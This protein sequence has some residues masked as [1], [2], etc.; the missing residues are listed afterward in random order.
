LIPST[1]ELPNIQLALMEVPGVPSNRSMSPVPETDEL[2]ELHVYGQISGIHPKPFKLMGVVE[3]QGNPRTL[4]EKYLKKDELQAELLVLKKRNIRPV[5]IPSKT[6]LA[7]DFLFAAG[8]IA[9]TWGNAQSKAIVK[10]LD[11]DEEGRQ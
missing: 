3:D 11:F 9:Q 6:S 7:H 8:A 2:W 4:F 5:L 1:P 10:P